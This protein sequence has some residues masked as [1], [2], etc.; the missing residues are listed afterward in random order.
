MISDEFL[1][2][3]KMNSEI[4]Q[5][6]SSYVPLKRKGRILNG[7][8]P[9][10]SEK[11]PSFTVYPEN[12]SFYCFGCGAGGDV[13][14]FVRKIENL[15]YVEAVRFLAQHAGM[16]MPEDN[17]NDQ[18]AHM[19]SRILEINRSLAHF[20]HGCLKQP[21]G[22]SGLDY[23]HERGLSNKTIIRFGLGFAPDSWDSALQHLK[24]KGFTEEEMLAAAVVSRSSK[25]NCY[26][27]F[28]GRVMFPIIDLRGN[29]IGFGGRIMGDA[30]G[31]KYLNSSDTPVFK[32]S[33]NLYAMGFAK[34][35][36]REGLLLCEGY[37]DVIA[38]HQAGFDNAVATLGTALTDEQA[39][40]AAQ[41]TNLV[42]LAYD[43]DGPGQ[44]ATRRASQIFERTGVK[45]RVLSIKN[46]KDPDEYIKKFGAERF[47][48]LIN[49]ANS[50][51]EF[52][53]EKLR[54]RYDLD[55]ADG[56]VAYLKEFIALI[57]GIPNTIER[58][59]YLTKTAT[60]LEVDK[61]ALATQLSYE[62]KKKNKQQKKKEGGLKV[63]SEMKP[64]GQKQDF[65]RS[66]NIKYALAEDKLIAILLKNPDYF[67]QIAA[68]I[69][70]DQFVTAR[71]R[72]IADVL[73]RRLQAGKSVELSM[74]SMDLDF[75]QMSVL[76]GLVNS[77]SGMT[78]DIEDAKSYV[79]T[80]LSK[81]TVK[82]QEEVAAMKE[83][84]LKDY[85]ASLASKK[86][87]GGL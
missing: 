21:V 44:A 45:V 12:Q 82:S 28:R 30:K 62:M 76:S 48:L 3:L 63:F 70:V 39:R 73:F 64:S 85:I 2:E 50:A 53:I 75:E 83:D 40:L 54:Q 69:E 16:T 52:E 79:E 24:Q 71:N 37:M 61:T 26:D 42:T 5:V 13:I 78:F 20:Y 72:A 25:G 32:K 68:L 57:A 9:F 46:A 38:V 59:V 74:L 35:S 18:V 47:G 77:I 81:K 27:Q 66:K 67:E 43:S 15:E 19:K 10:H 49:G 29:V 14:T 34:A 65:E 51:I 4:E 56:K 87:Q 1:Q 17:G 7:L 55:T 58:D 11:S 31:P 80:I 60:E 84:E 36:K 33:R 22:K 41:Y 23:L 6:I 8:C 86:K